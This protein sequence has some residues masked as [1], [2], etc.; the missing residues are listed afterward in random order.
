MGRVIVPLFFAALVFATPPIARAD[1]RNPQQLAFILDQL[2]CQMDPLGEWC[3]LSAM[4]KEI[5]T[6]D[7]KRADPIWAYMHAALFQTQRWIRSKY[8]LRGHWLRN[9]KRI[10]RAP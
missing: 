10:K 1:D 3:L 9:L 6:L 8:T 2:T 4:N 7:D 5:R